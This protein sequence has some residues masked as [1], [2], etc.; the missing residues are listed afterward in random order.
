MA[1]PAM[2]QRLTVSKAETDM[3]KV[4]W[5]QPVTAEFEMRNRSLRK[6]KIDDVIVSCGCTKVDYPK[7]EISGGDRFTLRLTYDA[8]QMGH[9]IKS[10]Y[11]YSNGSRKPVQVTMRGVV[12]EESDNYAENYPYTFGNIVTDRN[13]L[14]FDNVNKGDLPRAEIRLRNVGTTLVQP[15]LMHIPPYME[16]KVEPEYLRPGHTGKIVV[17]L[18]SDKLRDY[19]LTQTSLFLAN[20]P[21]EKVSDENEIPVTAILL[22]DFDKLTPAQLAAAPHIRLSAENLSFDFAAE[23][24]KKLKKEI[25][26]TNTGRSVLDISSMQM[27]GNGLRVTL[28]KQKLKPGETTQLKVTAYADDLSHSKTR[29]RILM[30]TNDPSKPKVVVEITRK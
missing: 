26:I 8:R 27:S 24:K 29:P 19:G 20:K 6:L 13:E 17:T 11:I 2:G 7:G 4:T 10:A 30:I 9:F 5:C 25:D 1:I 16:V 28:E 21:G 15:G 12:V 3:G 22:P 14:E 18:H 23:G